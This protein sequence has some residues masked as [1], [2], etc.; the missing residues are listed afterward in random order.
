MPDA[1]TEQSEPLVYTLRPNRTS[2]WL[3][4]W[5]TEQLGIARGTL[6][7]ADVFGCDAIQKLLAERAIR[8]RGSR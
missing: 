7:S 2:L 3:P 4:A 6:L 1:D 8:G 5:L